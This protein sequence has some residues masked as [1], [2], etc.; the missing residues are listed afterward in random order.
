MKKLS[1]LI[2]LAFISVSLHAA[3]K[4]KIAC[5]GNSITYGAGIENRDTDTYPAQLQRALGDEYEIRNFG[6]NGRTAL[7]NGNL[8]YVKTQEYKESLE[9]APDIVII[10]LGT[11]DSKTHNFGHIDEF[12]SN[13][14]DIIES[15]EAL[16]SSPRII[17]VSPL[18]CYLTRDV[19]Y[20]IDNDRLVKQITPMVQQAAYENGLEIINGYPLCGDVLVESILPD[21]LHPSAEGAG[22]MADHFSR[23]IAA[24]RDSQFDIFNTL[25]DGQEFN[26]YGYKGMEFASKGLNYKVVQPKVTNAQHSWVLR[27]RFWG[28]EPQVDQRL[29]EMGFHIVYCDV[30]DLY[31]SKEAVKRWDKFY[32]IMQRNGLSE[33][34]VLEGMSRGGLIVYNWAVKNPRKVAAIYADAPVL[35]LNSWPLGYAKATRESKQVL[36]LYGAKTKEQFS[37]FKV[38]PIDNAEKIAK[39]NIPI[40]HVIGKADDVVPYKDNTERFAEILKANGAQIEVIIKVGVGHH[41]HS[42]GDPKIIA[43]FI[44]EAVDL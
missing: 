37:T 21:K 36:T 28:H 23:V 9:F 26:F 24:K 6:V 38:N 15:Y 40:I 18:K 42:L 27:A 29:L 10:K 43:D 41:P 31:G 44:L 16:E 4:I 17:L 1:L 25:I 14:Q 20:T 5:I 33:K 7:F 13:Y 3:D 34:V 39:L 30:V 32:K 11:N 22:M 8:P 2:F 35:D 12:P 19:E